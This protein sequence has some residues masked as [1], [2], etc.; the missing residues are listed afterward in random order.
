MKK[1]LLVFIGIIFSF[2]ILESSLQ[3]AS[4]YYVKTKKSDSDIMLKSKDTITVLCLG[5]STTDG[6]WP[7]FLKQELE[8][9]NM[10]K[11]FV[12]VD[13]GVKATNTSVILKNVPD[14]IAQYKPDIIVA[15][16]GINDGNSDVMKIKMFPLKIFKLIYLI[17]RHLSQTKSVDEIL[18]A[19]DFDLNFLVAI[20]CYNENNYDQAEIVLKSLLKQYPQ[21]SIKIIKLLARVYVNR[22]Y[23]NGYETD[24]GKTDIKEAEKIVLSAIEKDEYFDINLILFV[25]SKAQNIDMIKKLFPT[26][27]IK[28]LRQLYAKD[29]W[30]FISHV[31]CLIDLKMYE[32]VKIIDE[33]SYDNSNINNDVIY[34]DRVI[35]SNATSLIQDKKFKK[36]EKYFKLQK[37][38]LLDTVLQITADNYNKL[39][40]ICR[41]NKIKLIAMQ[42]PVRPVEAL[43]AVFAGKT[44]VA[45]T[46]NEQSFKSLLKE[47]E[48]KEIFVDLFA[49]DFGHS[50]DLGNKTIAANVA[51][52]IKGLLN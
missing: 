2:I 22:A 48:L 30:A 23:V 3:I 8:K 28:L 47:K 51:E 13:K 27:D 26:D 16:M 17:K 24:K 1:I 44:D 39:Y 21:N 32:L 35:G 6:Q 4:F 41:Q 38:V 20:Q 43:K 46:D 33:I 45:F 40:D 50:T 42:Y 36:A 29:P 49:G 5:E 9:R 52:T 10:N 14:Y 31:K 18:E 34:K 19:T 15:M 7:K 37:K 25:L 11:N 12:I